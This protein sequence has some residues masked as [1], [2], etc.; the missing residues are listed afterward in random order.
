M[1][2]HPSQLMR[3]VFIV[4]VAVLV[5]AGLT[6]GARPRTTRQWALV[7]AVL[8]VLAWALLGFAWLRSA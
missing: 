2:W 5:I 4:L 7:W 8:V 3:I 6:T 1:P